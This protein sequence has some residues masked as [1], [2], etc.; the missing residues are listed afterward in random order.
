MG[1]QIRILMDRADGEAVL[2]GHVEVDESYVGGYR[3]GKRGRGAAGKTIVMGMKE[4][5]GRLETTIIPDVKKDTLREVVLGSVEA[6]TIVSTDE[7]YSYGLLTPA[8]YRYGAVKHGT[9]EWSRFY[10]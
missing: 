7:L 3:P 5:G 2:R 1:Q 4:H 6:G 8:G 10:P 9:K